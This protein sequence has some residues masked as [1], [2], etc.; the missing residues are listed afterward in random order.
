MTWKGS[1]GSLIDGRRKIAT[2][3]FVF[4]FLFF[5]LFS[6]FFLF[7]CFLFLFLFLFSFF[8]FLF[9]F[10]FFLFSFF[11]FL[12]SFFFFL[13][14]FFFFLFSFFL[15]LLLGVVV[16]LNMAGGSVLRFFPFYPLFPSLS[17]S[18]PHLPSRFFHYNDVYN[19]DRS[20][21]FIN[22]L[23][24]E[25]EEVVFVLCLCCGWLVFVVI[26]VLLG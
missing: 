9:S 23:V 19:V 22:L 12:F 8:L 18:H 26:L 10:F 15:F 1:I 6:F 4:C 7:F 3:F 24:K 17:S 21:P 11:F 2:F 13:F 25:K 5:V 20:P 16:S 14:S